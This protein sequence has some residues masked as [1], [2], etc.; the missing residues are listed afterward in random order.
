M[1]VLL[2]IKDLACPYQP[3]LQKNYGT[4][5]RKLSW[6]G[7]FSRHNSISKDPIRLIELTNSSYIIETTNDASGM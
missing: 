2:T 5:K 3:V 6:L 7:P 1:N 4:K